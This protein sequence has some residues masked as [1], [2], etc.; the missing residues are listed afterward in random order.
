MTMLREEPHLSPADQG[1]ESAPQVIERWL[2]SAIGAAIASGRRGLAFLL[3]GTV[4]GVGVAFLMP[5]RYESRA[6]FIA[7]KSSS[8]VIP[9]GL[10]GLAA[11]I[12]LGQDN[13]YS[14]RF[15]ADLA[16]SRPILLD[17]INHLYRVPFRDSTSPTTYMVIE[18]IE[19]DAPAQATEAALKD[20]AKRVT[21]RADVRT[22]MITLSVQARYP[23]LARDILDRLLESLDSLNIT[24]RQQQSRGLRQFYETRVRDAQVELDSTEAALQHF[25][26]RNRSTQN[27]PLL[28]FEQER[29]QRSVDVK[30]AV[31]TTIVQQYEQARLE[32]ARNVPTLTVLAE[33][34][35]PT[36]KSGPPRRLIVGLCAL[37]GLGLLWLRNRANGFLLRLKAEEP[38]A[39]QAIRNIDATLKRSTRS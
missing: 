38:E 13:D 11:S 29:L 28:T 33:P 23:T 22:N 3:V 1:Y 20:L 4:A 17:V 37:G 32:E 36:K 24:F 10:Q 31:Y 30:K 7:Q 21:A 12:G 19:E 18:H 26:E 2:R 6:V 9:A 39:W 34:Y 27:S 35:V 8:S 25:L 15:Y 14:P 5:N 16:S